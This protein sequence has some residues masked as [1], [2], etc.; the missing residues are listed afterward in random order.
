MVFLLSLLN[1][2]EILRINP[3]LADE[4]YYKASDLIS[5]YKTEIENSKIKMAR[6]K[7]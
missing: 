3:S 5:K 4:K 2:N 6:L 1:G 7:K